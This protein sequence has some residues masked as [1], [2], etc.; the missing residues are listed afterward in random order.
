MTLD[1]CRR[2]YA[3]EIRFAANIRSRALLDAFVRVPREDFLG[4]GPWQIPCPNPTLM[5]SLQYQQTE[6]ADPRRV[7]HN[8]TIALDTA[9][10]LNNGQPSSLAR[11][12]ENLE[13]K[14]GARVFHLG[15]GVGYYT[16]IMA[17]LAG[18]GGTV[19]AS[20]IHPELAGRA[21]KN[22]G[23]WCNV[24]VHA[25]DGVA[26]DPGPCDAIFIN[27]GV[28]HVLPQWLEKLRE[29]GR[30]LVPLTV[31]MGSNLGK[32]IMVVIGRERDGFSA[33]AT[34]M[35]A[36][37][38]CGSARDAKLE[39]ALGQ[40]MQRMG[41]LKTRSLRTDVHDADETCSFHVPGACLSTRELTSAQKSD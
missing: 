13:I 35:V 23:R 40:A 14:P 34:D 17:E 6:D 24:E 9:K 26:L 30:I 15:C 5:S 36:I 16:A 4:A 31:A 41:I 32:G 38:N 1:E 21:Q 22:L 7:Y 12:I 19:V 39:P 20:E 37:Y 25:G 10:D 11:W 28:T 18:P 3:E 2:F 8:V 29:G 33:R 27:A